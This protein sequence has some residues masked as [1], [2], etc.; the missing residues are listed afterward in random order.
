MTD[1]A[2]R[3][4]FTRV[5]DEVYEPL[6][7]YLRRRCAPDD[8]DDVLND[9]LLTVWRRIDDTPDGSALPWCYGI[10]RRCLANHWRT[11]ARRTRLVARA[12]ASA[13]P[14]AGPIWVDEA[15][16]LLHD[17]LGRLSDTD[18]EIV[19]LWAWERLEPREIALVL[20]S[21]P[22]AVSVRL[23]RLR[24]ALESEIGRQDLSVAGHVPGDDHPELES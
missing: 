4:A 19:R 10:A 11:A 7:R 14:A 20:D 13:A 15:D 24:R 12:M 23:S 6:Q 3:A 5:T 22:N 16:V 21:T 18:R 2:R 17:A 9:V 8:V 1:A